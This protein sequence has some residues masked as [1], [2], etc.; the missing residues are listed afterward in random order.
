MLA[1][2]Q[3]VMKLMLCVTICIEDSLALTHLQIRIVES[4]NIKRGTPQQSTLFHT[5]NARIVVVQKVA[6]PVQFL[7]GVQVD[8]DHHCIYLASDW[9]THELSLHGV[10][11]LMQ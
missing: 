5:A 9:I 4:A 7:V 11:C 10:F 3:I 8:M 6:V 2:M 1:V